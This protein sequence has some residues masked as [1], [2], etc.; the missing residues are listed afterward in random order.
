VPLA[1]QRLERPAT[2]RAHPKATDVCLASNIIEVGVDVDRLS[3]ICV[4]G[5]PKT[6]AQYIQV[7]GRV[8][9]KWWERPG[10]VLAV[11]VPNKPRD[12]SHFERF[13][14]YH[15]RLYAQVEPATYDMVSKLIG[16]PRPGLGQLLEPIQSYCLLKRLPP[17]TILVVSE[18]TGLPGTGFIAAEDIP[19]TQITVF[20]HDWIAKSAPSPEE[21]DQA[22]S[23]MPSN[24]VRTS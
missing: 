22:V 24:G 21:L 18:D 19:K 17:L 20:A 16:V 13:R 14:T 3:L 2:T 15:E 11:Y 12:R 23:A 8:G 1:L 10:L 9:R 7:T 6:T 4:N 5:Q